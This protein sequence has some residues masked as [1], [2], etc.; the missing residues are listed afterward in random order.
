LRRPEG[1]D[2]DRRGIVRHVGGFRGIRA[3][4]AGAKVFNQ[5]RAC[6]QIGETAKN[7][8]GPKLNCVIGRKTGSVDGFACGSASKDGGLTWDEATFAE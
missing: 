8:V 7:L 5:C 6:D 3:P 4:D 1:K 2:H